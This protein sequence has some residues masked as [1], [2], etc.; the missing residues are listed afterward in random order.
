MEQMTVISVDPTDGLVCAAWSVAP[1]DETLWAHLIAG[2][3]LRVTMSSSVFI[4][5]PPPIDAAN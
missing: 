3:K 4:H 2:M 1:G 5:C